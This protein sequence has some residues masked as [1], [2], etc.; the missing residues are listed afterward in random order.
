VSHAELAYAKGEGTPVTWLSLRLQ[1]GPVAVVA[2]L[3][4]DALAEPG[5]DAWFAALEVTA[6]PNVLLPATASCTGTASFAHVAWPRGAGAV[7]TALALERA[8]DVQAALEEQGLSLS[9][10]LPVAARYL[11]WSWNDLPEAQTTRT[12]RVRGGS[13]PLALSAGVAFPVLVNAL[14]PGARSLPDELSSEQLQVTFELGDPAH[15]DYGDRLADWLAARPEP[16]LE[17]RAGGPVFDWSV[18]DNQL[19]LPPLLRSYAVRAARELPELNPDDCS[20]QLH[21]LRDPSAPA[22]SACGEARDAELAL[23][24]VGS[25]QITLQRFAISSRRG[26]VPGAA[27][28]GG[29]GRSPLLRA[30][31]TEG[32]GCQS[33]SGPV[34]MDRTPSSGAAQAEPPRD[35]SSV[36]VE[37]TVVVDQ[38]TDAGCSASTESGQ[39]YEAS[40]QDSGCS[41][42]TSSSSSDTSND[43]CSGDSSTSSSS[44]TS[45]DSC[46]GDSSSSSDTTS[47]SCSGDSSTSSSSSDDK[48][49]GSDSSSSSSSSDDS[50][51]GSD[52]GS[53]SNSGYDG[54]TCTGSAAP[55]GERTQK[56]QAG[57]SGRPAAR[58]KRLKTSLW[59]LAFA[60]VILPIRRRKRAL[61]PAS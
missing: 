15:S 23:R 4:D 31:Q 32:K 56:A 46:S 50:G 26:L 54:D 47:D 25:E 6:S 18:Y 39:G 30:T 7:E 60:A 2:A 16:L 44:D 41:S 13:D 27:Q 53:D 58:P 49:C 57:L 21:A 37:E 17:M 35:D 40:D 20:E 34:V 12:L 36:A 1:R 11:I 22:A 33:V 28:A 19:S 43:S 24:A 3:P 8:E 9:E 59:T 61:E 29:N 45:N 38:R 52:S 42:D 10:P 51:C 55:G 48:G 14:T 5:L